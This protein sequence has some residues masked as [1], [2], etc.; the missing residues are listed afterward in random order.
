MS[1]QSHSLEDFPTVAV[2]VSPVRYC[3]I[4]PHDGLFQPGD[5][6]S[7]TLSNVEVTSGTAIFLLGPGLAYRLHDVDFTAFRLSTSEATFEALDV[8]QKVIVGVF[9]AVTAGHQYQFLATK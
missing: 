5:N 1:T 4:R 8:V 7:G 2:P 6:V 9:S 3:L